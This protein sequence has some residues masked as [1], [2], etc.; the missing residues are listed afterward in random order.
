MDVMEA[1]PFASA[2][3]VPMGLSRRRLWRWCVL[4][5]LRDARL[6]ASRGRPIAPGNLIRRFER[7]WWRAVARA[8]STVNSETA[9]HRR[10]GHGKWFVHTYVDRKHSSTS[11]RSRNHG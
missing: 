1:W 8:R 11:T 7:R 3:R 4:R 10:L 6:G 2:C 5:T 9:A